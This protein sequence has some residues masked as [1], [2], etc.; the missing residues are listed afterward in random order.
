MQMRS[1]SPTPLDGPAD[2]TVRTRQTLVRRTVVA[3]VL[4]LTV[5]VGTIAAP[6]PTVAPA[7]AAT[8]RSSSPEIASTAAAALEALAH[9][10]D[11][12]TPASYVRFLVA[13]DT[14]AD[15]AAAELGLDAAAMRAA[16]AGVPTVKQTALLAAL[17]QLGVPYRSMKSVE[18]VGFDCSGLMHYA[19]GRAGVVLERPSGSQI[20]AAQ[21]VARDEAAAG[22][23]VY[24]PGHISMYLGVAD[25]IVH[26]PNSG[27]HVEI[28]FVNQRR[29]RSVIFGDPLG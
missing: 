20:R 22:D 3:V 6:G 11:T 29:A 10:Q 8:P 18:G 9:W 27:N 5:G 19:W 16:W 4:G 28:T 13:R 23:F 24:Y 2:P 21:R 14:A 25:A 17:S 12:A 15:H 26:S 7:V 1:L